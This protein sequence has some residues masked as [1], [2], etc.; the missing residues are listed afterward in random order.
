MKI[1]NVVF[2]LSDAV[3]DADR[4]VVDLVRLCRKEEFTDDGKTDKICAF[5][6]ITDGEAVRCKDCK[7]RD[8]DYCTSHHDHIDRDDF[9]SRGERKDG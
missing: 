7:Y 4:I 6:I 9:C 5:Q 3:S 8:K 1:K 2:L